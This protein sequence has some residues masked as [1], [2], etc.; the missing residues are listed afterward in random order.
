MNSKRKRMP[1]GF[2][3]VVMVISGFIVDA[4]QGPV[5][6]GRTYKDNSGEMVLYGIVCLALS[7]LFIVARAIWGTSVSYFKKR[8]SGGD[9]NVS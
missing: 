7:A 8:R 4:M 6:P 2:I 5:L 3:I 9:T 1:V